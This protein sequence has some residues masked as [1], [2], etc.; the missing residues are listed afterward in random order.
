M[1]LCWT[2]RGMNELDGWR[3]RGR[4]YGLEVFMKSVSAEGCV[5]TQARMRGSCSWRVG[6]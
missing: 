5:G 1:K 6:C 3:E 4:T 2:E